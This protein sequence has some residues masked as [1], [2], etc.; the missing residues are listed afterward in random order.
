MFGEDEVSGKAGGAFGEVLAGCAVPCRVAVEDGMCA[1]ERS[2][3]FGIRVR[4]RHRGIDGR[5]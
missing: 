2:E 3:R 4:E 1:E 5:A